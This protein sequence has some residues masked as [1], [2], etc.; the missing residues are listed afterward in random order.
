MLNLTID[1]NWILFV[2]CA[3]HMIAE[4]VGDN[5]SN[6]YN[7]VRLKSLLP[8]SKADK[9]ENLQLQW[10]EIGHTCV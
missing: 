10:V 5:R 9:G 4:I 7:S 6:W 8:L 2:S 3:Y 1:A